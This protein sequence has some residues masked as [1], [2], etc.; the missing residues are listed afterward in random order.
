MAAAASTGAVGH[1]I[2]A[3][4]QRP[5]GAQGPGPIPS[6]LVQ[7]L[8]L[9]LEQRVGGLLPGEHRAAGT[10]SGTELAQIRPYRP[11]D[12]PRSLDAAASA[13]TGVPHVREHVPERVLTSWIVVDV[14]PSM[15]FGTALRLKSDVAQGAAKVLA[16]LAGRGGGRVGVVLAGA[17]GIPLSPPRGG[18]RAVL[19]VEAALEGGVAPDPTGEGG[20]ADERSGL[21][22][23]L[24]RVGRVT[25]RAGFIA[26][27]SDF[28][29]QDGWEKVLTGLGQRHALCC[30]EVHDP[31][32]AELP[33]VGRVL[34][35]DPETGRLVEVDTSDAA[36]RHRYAAAEASRRAALVQAFR[37][38]RAAHVD[39]STGED[40]LR[41]LGRGLAP[42]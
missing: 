31:R 5:P 8:A 19:A 21:A 6:A 2:G 34:M 41:G 14:S 26:V 16:R 23:A 15:A 10:G 12:D 4:L 13:R 22:A 3:G 30:V 9:R 20:A 35:A 28:R 37:R 33:A 17:P 24:D 36:L 18:R 42:R 32:E 11:G 38:A 39:L 25:Q 40:W 1:R 7:G 29:E 27:V